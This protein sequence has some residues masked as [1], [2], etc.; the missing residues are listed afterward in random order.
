[1]P[2]DSLNDNFE[3]SF[4]R[5]AIRVG[6]NISKATEKSVEERL[7]CVENEPV[8]PYESDAYRSVRDRCSM[9]RIFEEKRRSPREESRT[10]HS[11]LEL[12]RSDW[13]FTRD[14]SVTMVG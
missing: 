5:R 6:G 1:M 10:A 13:S 11:Y 4:D 7:G 2:I 3:R 14:A 8:C 9:N 12:K